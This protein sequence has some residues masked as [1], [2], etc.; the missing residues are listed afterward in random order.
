VDSNGAP[1]VMTY[2]MPHFNLLF[3]TQLLQAGR[4]RR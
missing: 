2:D 3:D 1:A 4:E